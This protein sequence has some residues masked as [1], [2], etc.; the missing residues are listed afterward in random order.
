MFHPSTRP[1][2]GAIG[3]NSILMQDNA[4]PHTASVCT[5]YLNSESI[6]G[7]DWPAHSPDLR[8]GKKSLRN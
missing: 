5:D 3:D 8:V 2:A 1:S 4:R 6:E 7:M